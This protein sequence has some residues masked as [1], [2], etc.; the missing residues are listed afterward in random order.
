MVSFEARRRSGET[1]ALRE[2]QTDE[3]CTYDSV[4]FSARA[5]ERGRGDVI[6]GWATFDLPFPREQRKCPRA[7]RR[8]H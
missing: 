3:T 1:N 4:Y 7:A 2:S 8:N 6:R 5:Q